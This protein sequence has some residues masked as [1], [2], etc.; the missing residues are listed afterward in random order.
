[1][2]LWRP[3]T[4]KSQIKGASL[5]LLLCSDVFL[6]FE[7]LQQCCVLNG[8]WAQIQSI[9]DVSRGSIKRRKWP[10]V[11]STLN[12]QSIPED[13]VAKLKTACSNHPLIS[14]NAL[15]HQYNSVIPPE[16]L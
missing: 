7:L 2:T 15:P 13:E 1:M 9:T 8:P 12:T 16:M 3:V 10:D 6:T 14:H 5:F 4:H 11:D